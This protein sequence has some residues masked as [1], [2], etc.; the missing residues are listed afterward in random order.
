[1]ASG[2]ARFIDM[3]RA[4][5]ADPAARGLVDDVAVLAF[6]SECLV[7]THDM[8][9]E[10]VHWLRGQDEADVAWKLV[11][12]NLSDLAAKGAAPIGVL[13]GYALGA[14]DARFAQG[15]GEALRAFDVALLGGDTVA[16]AAGGR[17][18][19]LTALGRATHVPVPGRGGARPG[20]RLWIT[21]PVGAA[22]LGF[23]ALRDGRSGV[24]SRA[25][26]RPQPRL[27]EGIAL[28]PQVSAMMDVSDGLLIDAQRLALTS[29]VTL[30]IESAAVPFPESLP[31]ERRREAMAWGDDYELLFALPPNQ[32]PACLAYAIGRVEEFMGN[33]VLID[34]APPTGRLGYWHDQPDH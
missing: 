2:E 15:L 20:D 21:G 26:R 17:S 6:G 7:I 34:G 32:T 23:E 12:T 19:G 33:S 18:H 1:M 25:F 5:A 22:M 13:L 16:A 11:A 4:L 27:A 29:G 28:A 3:M 31:K 8:M 9:V 14:D 10:G 24:D 30:A